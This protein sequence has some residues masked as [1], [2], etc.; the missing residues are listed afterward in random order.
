MVIKLPSNIHNTTTRS[1]ILVVYIIGGLC[2]ANNGEYIF[3]KKNGQGQPTD[4]L[5]WFV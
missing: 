4:A 5:A 2:H 1:V 3:D